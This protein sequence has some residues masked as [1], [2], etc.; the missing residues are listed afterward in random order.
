LP[1]VT[2]KL[3]ENLVDDRLVRSSDARKLRF[4]R[5]R[6][7]ILRHEAVRWSCFDSV[8]RYQRLSGVESPLSKPMI[9]AV[10][11]ILGLAML[12]ATNT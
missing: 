10:R 8:R 4:H 6:P 3:N 1:T 5:P 2:L 9:V 7:V 12:G 11:R